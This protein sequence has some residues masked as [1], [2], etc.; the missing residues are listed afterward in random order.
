MKVP[1]TQDKHCQLSNF[2]ELY[3]HCH[4]PIKTLATTSLPEYVATHS[5][6]TDYL[7]PFRTRHFARFCGH[8]SEV[9]FLVHLDG[10][11]KENIW[12]LCQEISFWNVS[13]YFCCSRRRQSFFGTLALHLLNPNKQPQGRIFQLRWSLKLNTGKITTYSMIFIALMRNLSK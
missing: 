12:N 4:W 1:S 13:R 2:T 8:D 3:C 9:L 5:P 6:I 7:A 10:Q 11:N